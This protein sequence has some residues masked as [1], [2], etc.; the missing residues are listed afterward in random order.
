MG[1]FLGVSALTF[2]AFTS[3]LETHA[4]PQ[5]LLLSGGAAYAG[6]IVAIL[7]LG[8][9]SKRPEGVLKLALSGL[10]LSFLFF[11]PLWGSWCIVTAVAHLAGWGMDGLGF[12]FVASL[13]WAIVVLGILGIVAGISRSGFWNRL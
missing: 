3:L 9:A 1:T 5:W 11:I 6:P 12:V 13:L 7:L 8:W 4:P 10:A 2:K